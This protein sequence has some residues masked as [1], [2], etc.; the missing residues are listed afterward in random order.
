[1]K[2]VLPWV[3]SLCWLVLGCDF[4]PAH[5]PEEPPPVQTSEGETQVSVTPAEPQPEPEPAP[6][7]AGQTEEPIEA[8]VHETNEQTRGRLAKGKITPVLEAH[9]PEF[10]RCYSDALQAEPGLS[11][12]VLL[13]LVIAPDGSVPHAQVIPGG[14]TLENTQVHLCLIRE[15]MTLTFEKPVGGRVVTEYPLEFAP[16]PATGEASLPAEGVE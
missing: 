1:M 2:R 10:T 16:A 6:V 15:A 12:R 7:D 4:P 8:G 9:G 5:P 3:S 11:G 14:T 13:L